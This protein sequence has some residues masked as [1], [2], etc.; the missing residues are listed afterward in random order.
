MESESRIQ[1]DHS[2]VINSRSVF[3]RFTP[4]SSPPA[5]PGEVI[6]TGKGRP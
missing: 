4:N 5:D 3:G 1:F 2:G 6:I